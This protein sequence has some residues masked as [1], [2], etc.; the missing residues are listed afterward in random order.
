MQFAPAPSKSEL[1]TS[2]TGDSV[3]DSKAASASEPSWSAVKMSNDK[4]Y[5]FRVHAD[6][7]AKTVSWQLKEKDGVS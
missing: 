7:T 3:D 1:R 6:F 2:T 5:T 4:T